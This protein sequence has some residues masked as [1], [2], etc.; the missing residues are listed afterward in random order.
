MLHQ[1]FRRK[2]R[3]LGPLSRIS[4]EF[5]RARPVGTELLP[6]ALADPHQAGSGDVGICS[7][8]LRNSSKRMV[9]K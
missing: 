9:L 5:P 2:A 7:A 3:K 4:T 8:R 6:G 1:G